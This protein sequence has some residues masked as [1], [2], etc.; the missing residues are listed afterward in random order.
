MPKNVQKNRVNN[1][2]KNMTAVMFFF[3]SIQ[4]DKFKIGFF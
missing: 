1:L 3:K 4:K 2:K